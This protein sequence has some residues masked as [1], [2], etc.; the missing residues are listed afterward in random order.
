MGLLGIFREFC[1]YGDYQ[2]EPAGAYSW[3]HLTLVAVVLTAMVVLAV[4]F[5]LKNKN[6]DL[7]QKNRVLVWSAILIDAFEMFKIIVMIT[8]SDEPETAWHNLLPLFLC[9]IQLI[10]IPLAAFTKGRIKRASL[11]FVLIFG[12][13]GAVLGTVGAAQN[14]ANYPVLS[15]DNVVS[16]ITHSISGFASLYIAISGMTSL[17]KR[18]LPITYGILAFFCVAAYS[19]NKVLDTNYMFLMS[20]DG[21]PYSLLTALVKGNSTLYAFGVIFLFVI[22]IAVFYLTH[23]LVV[24]NKKKKAQ[25]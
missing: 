1:G 6:K 20:D 23:T 14:Y 4:Y 3:Q 11:D 16:A 21:T 9:S 25:A 15:M 18:D 8:R 19:V 12:I 13:L 7:A 22:Y 5:G 24:R 10:T 17:K 2:R